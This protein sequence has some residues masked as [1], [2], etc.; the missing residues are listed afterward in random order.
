MNL[1]ADFLPPFDEGAAQINFVLPPGSSLDASNRASRMV[2]AALKK[3]MFD[4]AKNPKGLVTSFVRRSG[5]AELD[6][7]AEG[8]NVTE[9]IVS[10]NPRSGQS[11]QLALAT[12]RTELG[13]I[14][15]LEY[16]VEQPLAHLISHML[17]GVT[18]QIAIKVFG[19]DL[20]ILRQ[21]ADEIKAAIQEIPG[22]APPMVEPQRLIPQLRIELNREQLAQHG[23]TAG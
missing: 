21:K 1:G 17:S 20:D 15:G 4:A 8:V 12:L 2:D 9:Y 10:L 3:H 23:L 14:A 11:R 19:E 6:E 16:E 5:R 18:A 7:H 13:E 22:L